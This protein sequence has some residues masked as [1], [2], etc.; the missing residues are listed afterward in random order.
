VRVISA[1]SQPCGNSNC[2]ARVRRGRRT[3][4]IVRHYLY[5]WQKSNGSW[6]LET[7][8]RT[9]YLCTIITDSKFYPFS[10]KP[11]DKTVHLLNSHYIYPL[12]SFPHFTSYKFQE[13]SSSLRSRTARTKVLT[14][15]HLHSNGFSK[16]SELSGFQRKQQICCS[17]PTPLHKSCFLYAA[18]VSSDSSVSET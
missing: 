6:N 12:F 11:F 17:I 13:Q 1:V 3:S 18:Q 4:S 14:F 15:F 8:E 16:I 2:H 10:F 7:A 5:T 9:F